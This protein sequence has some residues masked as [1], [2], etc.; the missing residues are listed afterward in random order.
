MSIFRRGESTPSANDKLL[1]S[2]LKLEQ[3]RLEHSSQVQAKHDEL[4]LRKLEIELQNLDHQTKARIEL[5]KA[6]QELR[7]QR[8]ERAKKAVSKRWAN[9]RGD[10]PAC[11]LCRDPS[12]RNV[13]VE[14]I[15]A[16]RS[17]EGARAPVDFVQVPGG[18]PN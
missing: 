13:T 6:R 4:E 12:T 10:E 14:M 8:Q 15:N 11:E 3:S 16:H 18:K 9:A 17:H 2:L 7:F 5:D 1:D